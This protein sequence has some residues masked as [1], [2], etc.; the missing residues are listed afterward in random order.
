MIKKNTAIANFP[1]GVF[2]SAVDG[3]EVTTG[4]PVGTY[5]A[6]GSAGSIVGVISYDAIAK[7]WW[8][9][10][11]SAETNGD[12]CSYSFNLTGCLPINISIQTTTKLISDLNDIPVGSD[13]NVSK[14]LGQTPPTPNINGVPVVDLVYVSGITATGNDGTSQ[15]G[16]SSTIILD[17]SDISDADT[18]NGRTITIISE[19]G[20]GQSRIITN[21][22][23]PSTHIATVN[24]D[25]VIIPDSTSKYIID[26]TSDINLDQIL[27]INDITNKTTQTVGD[28]LSVARADGAGK[29]S[30]V[31]N[32][33][34]IYG[35]DNSIIIQFVLDDTQNPTTRSP[36][37]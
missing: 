18:L 28:A 14:W 3:S 11:T 9:S 13:V 23:G 10:L 22:E 37:V 7:S 12:L 33:L 34:T 15:G 21:Y 20:S 27:P 35:P 6:D 4:T 26:A 32:L 16:T 2:V 36:N 29:W 31:G 19:T 25:W 24:R 8:T 5:R 30:I 17:A 1:V